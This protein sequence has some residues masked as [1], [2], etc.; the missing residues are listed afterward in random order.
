[1]VYNPQRAQQAYKTTSIST[2][3]QSRLIIMLFEGAMRFM[4]QFIDAVKRTSIEEAHENSIKAQRIMTELI[5][6]LD[7][8]KGG[9]TSRM[10]EAAYDNIRGRMANAN[11]RKDIEMATKVIRDLESFRDTWTQV[12]REVDRE[13]A[14]MAPTEGGVSIKT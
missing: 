3:S 2:A 14:P 5:I 4:N 11:I 12:F 6:A 1:M 13:S 7:H 8:S 9:D 10:I